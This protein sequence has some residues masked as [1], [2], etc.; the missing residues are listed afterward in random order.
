M[1]D[2]NYAVL[3]LGAGASKEYDLPLGFELK[4]VIAQLLEFK[5]EHSY[6]PQ[7][8]D[9][10]VFDALRTFQLDFPEKVDEINELIAAGREI[11]AGLPQAPS[12]DQYIFNQSG[13][14]KIETVGKIAITRAIQISE[15]KSKLA[16]QI[17]HN[18]DTKIRRFSDW[19]IDDTWLP[20]LFMTL[21][22]GCASLDA[23][24]ERLSKI[25]VISFNYD[26]VFKHYLYFALRNYYPESDS[27]I[28]RVLRTMS[29]VHPY[30]SLGP[31]EWEDNRNGLQFGQKLDGPRLAEVASGIKTFNESTESSLHEVVRQSMARA[32]LVMFLGFGYHQQN[33]DFLASP[34]SVN[35]KVFGTAR[36][37]SDFDKAMISEELSQKLEIDQHSIF[38][39]GGD[40]ATLF[41]EYSRAL[42][43]VGI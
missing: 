12:I 18:Y 32:K 43:L 19:K 14:N 10:V 30:G 22:D 38:L 24:E 34:N 27:R 26:R 35:G 3:V 16:T 11:I 15:G 31:L 33:I 5:F 6:L 23:L 41:G 40:C 13:K 2:K 17:P 4:S 36:G 25:K 29:V 28:A 8:G 39:H 20:R 42:R 1:S 37:M 21:V 9:I 7:K